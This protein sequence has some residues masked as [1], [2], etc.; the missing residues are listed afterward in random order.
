MMS[1]MNSRALPVVSPTPPRPYPAADRT[2]RGNPEKATLGSGQRV[3]TTVRLA[4]R[5]GVGIF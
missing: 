4:P 1:G 2:L 5:G 3:R